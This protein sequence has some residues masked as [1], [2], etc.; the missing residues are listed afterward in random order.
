MR[1]IYYY[2]YT[3]EDIGAQREVQSKMKKKL[4]SRF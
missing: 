1:C 2:L 4:E 3:N